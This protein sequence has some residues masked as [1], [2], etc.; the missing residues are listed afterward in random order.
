MVGKSRQWGPEF[1][2]VDF[3]A[4]RL[5]YAFATV[6]ILLAVFGWRMVVL[7]EF[8][9]ADAIAFVFWFLLPDIVAFVPI[10]FSRSPKG[11][12]PPWGSSLYNVM[13]SFL[14]WAGVFLIAWILSGGV[15][16]PLLGWAAHITIDRA[17]GFQLRAK[18]V[19]PE[20]S[21]PE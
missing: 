17:A 9:A 15:V 7:K 20:S 19:S 10:G 18:S 21:N 12:W 14:P 4:Y 1:L 13:H 11:T 16:W 5:E 8:V 2:P 3:W 6:A